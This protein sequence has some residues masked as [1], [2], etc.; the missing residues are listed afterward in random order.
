VIALAIVL[1]VLATGADDGVAFRAAYGSIDKLEALGAARPTTRWTDDAW[2]EAGQLAER[3][4]DFDRARR[5]YEAALA[6]ATDPQLAKRARGMRDRLDTI[7]G[8]GEWTEVARRH[9]ALATEVL[10][11]GE[12]QDALAGLEAIVRENPRYPRV[13]AVRVLLAKAWEREGDAERAVAWL[14][15]A[16]D[17]ATDAERSSLQFALVG[18]LVRSGDLDGAEGEAAQLGRPDAMALVETARS[19]RTWRRVLLALVLAIGALA[20]GALRREAGSWRAAC[21]RLWPPPFEVWFLVPIGAV[22]TLVSRTGNPLVARAV[23]AVA[24]AGGAV[25]WISGALLANA[26][27]SARRIMLH[28]VLA[29]VA[30]AACTYLAVDHGRLIDLLSETWRSGPALP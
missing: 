24:L 3:A 4:G 20:I 30:V 9:E 26:P 14:R 23:L 12:P 2:Y 25:S 27:R 15:E 28:V 16:V 22:L 6:V 7:T 5:D 11:D 1:A 8:G 17:A 13:Q 19:R 10:G 21:R 18:M 29:L